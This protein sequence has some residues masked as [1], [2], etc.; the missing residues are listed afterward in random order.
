MAPAV[1]N[2]PSGL[3]ARGRLQSMGSLEPQDIIE[4]DR[5]PEIALDLY[6]RDA[7]SCIGGM[8]L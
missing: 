6:W 8:R 1:L 4:S 5:P 3:R 2:G 7:P